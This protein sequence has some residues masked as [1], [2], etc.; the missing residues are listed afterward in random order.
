MVKEVDGDVIKAALAG[1]IGVI[2]HGVNCYCTQKKGIA[3][4]MSQTFQTHFFP[5]EYS[6]EEGDINKLGQIDFKYIKM[7]DSSI[8]VVNAYTQFHWK[9]PSIYGIPLDYDAFRLCFRKI[10]FTFKQDEVGI[11]FIGTGLAK[12][13]PEIVRKILN[14]ECKNIKLTIYH[15][16]KIV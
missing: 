13:D 11:P 12:G 5:L 9:N 8:W 4:N 15:M 1:D 6:D 7:K 14:E 3:L 16:N 2:A 10:N